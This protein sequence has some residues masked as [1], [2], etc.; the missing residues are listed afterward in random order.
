MVCQCLDTD[1]AL[2][3]YSDR[4]VDVERKNLMKEALGYIRSFFWITILKQHKYRIYP[5]AD[6]GF[7]PIKYRFI[8]HWSINPAIPVGVFNR[9]PR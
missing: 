5:K 7:Q 9:N 6:G 8:K 3:I 4:D 1:L 2:Y